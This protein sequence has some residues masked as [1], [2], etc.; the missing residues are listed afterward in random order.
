MEPGPQQGRRTNAKPHIT[1]PTSSVQSVA[2]NNRPPELKEF[3]L[4][5]PSSLRKAAP[6]AKTLASLKQNTRFRKMLLFSMNKT[7]FSKAEGV[8][9]APLGDPSED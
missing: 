7:S 8:L 2:P 9:K 1:N 3:T 5:L 4:T 6:E